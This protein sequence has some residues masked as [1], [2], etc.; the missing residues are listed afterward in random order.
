MT[1]REN[2]VMNVEAKGNSVMS[3][4]EKEIMSMLEDTD[5]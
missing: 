2:S 5:K 1:R 3:D 4:E